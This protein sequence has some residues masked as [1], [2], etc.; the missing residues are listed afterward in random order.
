MRT[1]KFCDLG[2]DGTN[3]VPPNQDQQR[4]ENLGPIRCHFDPKESDSIW[5]KTTFGRAIDELR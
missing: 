4:I 5:S 1:K 2:P 3:L